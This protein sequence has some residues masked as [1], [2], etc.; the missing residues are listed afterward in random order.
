MSDSI[1]ESFESTGKIA[2]QKYWKWI[3]AGIAVIFAVVF[4][5]KR[6]GGAPSLPS[7]ETTS[8]QPDIIPLLAESNAAT[9]DLIA[10]SN[11]A[12]IKAIDT[13]NKNII[14]SI[15]SIIGNRNIETR[16]NSEDVSRSV[17]NPVTRTIRY[18]I[19][20]D[21]VAGY[22]NRLV[23]PANEF[24]RNIALSKERYYEAENAGDKSA[25]ETAHAEAERWRALA[26]QR[27][28]T[29]AEWAR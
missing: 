10:Q 23:I 22:V 25:Q 2:W 7:A 6:R 17:S 13:S 11:D 18:W 12:T 19:D 5:A 27:G 21:R 9:A 16:I 14:S 4:L 20:D 28:I 8:P 3:L 15:S 24:E 1:A 29:L 26:K